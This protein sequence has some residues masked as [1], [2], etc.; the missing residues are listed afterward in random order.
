VAEHVVVGTA[1]HVDHGKTTLVKALTGVDCDRLPEEKTRG[2]TIE[3]GFAQ[4][5]LGAGL[6]ASIVDVPGHERFV[7]TMVAGAAGIDRVLLVVAADDG[8]MPQTREHLAI[9]ALLGVPKGVIAITK[10]DRVDEDMRLLVEDD[11]RALVKGTFLEGAP[12]VRVAVPQGGGPPEG[13]AD[14][15]RAL[16][17]TLDS[18]SDPAASFGEVRARGAGGAWCAIDR[19][20]TR[21]GAGTVV[22][23]TLVSG[24]V[25]AGDALDA[26]PTALGGVA[27]VKVRSLEVH[28]R[29][30]PIAG[31][32]T[33]VALAVRGDDASALRRGGVLCSPGL[34]TPTSVL[35]AE[36]TLVPGARAWGR[37]TELTLHLGTAEHIVR[38]RTLAGDA[39]RLVRLSRRASRTST[40]PS[41]PM[42]AYPGQRLVLRRPDLDELRTIAG[43]VVV[44]PHP[45]RRQRSAPRD[46]AAPGATVSPIEA[47]VVE[48]GYAGLDRTAVAQRLA[49]GIDLD[50]A[51]AELVKERRIAES[52]HRFFARAVVD[53][54][55]AAVTT[56]LA[57]LH[58]ERPLSAGVSP[59]E[60]ETRQPIRLRRVVAIALGELVALQT[61]AVAD[62]ALR[63]ATHDPRANDL[64]DRVAGCF[65][66]ARLA[67]PS[68][69]QVR[70]EAGLDPARFRDVLADLKRRGVVQ[71][72]G[73]GLHVHHEA[74]SELEANV[75]GWFA[76]NAKLTP[77]DLKTLCGGLT[78]K[79]A[80]PLLEW[81][82]RAGVTR[83]QGDV[84]VAGPRC[85]ASVP[86]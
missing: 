68:D 74:L 29:E 28:G 62:G 34:Q 63:L 20:F 73:G 83:R 50:R 66:R 31:A 60:V 19:V 49:P 21:P 78:R 64:A 70:A 75:R 35:I 3:L 58:A 39:P 48:S 52:D 7:H 22:T 55:R 1:G 82:D 9:C 26:L 16:V 79:H 11:V 46:A 30:T 12:I 4:W 67:P 44:D 37:A 69:D 18:S 61:V 51:L 65:A 42:V 45:P 77:P 8:V 41:A 5:E 10:C 38:A 86:G 33:R 24:V 43:G 72:L 23:G 84:R 15:A 40:A 25:R 57:A 6:T 85:K 59:S 17:S 27:S 71:A 81:L 32:P 14:L 47:L 13:T 56:T 2:I 36:L 54:A 76:A 80:I 53:E